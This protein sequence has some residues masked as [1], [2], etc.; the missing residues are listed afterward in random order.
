M[1]KKVYVIVSLREEIT[2]LNILPRTQKQV[3][4]AVSEVPTI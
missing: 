4:G 1:K 2:T 3:V